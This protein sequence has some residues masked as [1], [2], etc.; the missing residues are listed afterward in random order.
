MTVDSAHTAD[1]LPGLMPHPPA[2][3][4]I[5]SAPRPGEKTL[6]VPAAQFSDHFHE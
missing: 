5:A 4:Q 6:W 2:F 3:S 1:V